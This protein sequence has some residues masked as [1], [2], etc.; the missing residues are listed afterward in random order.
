MS[1]KHKRF[2]IILAVM[3]AILLLTGCK[4][5]SSE[6]TGAEES[7]QDMFNRL[8]VYIRG[9]FEE[10]NVPGGS[11]A[12]ITNRILSY[13]SGIGVRRFDSSDQVDTET[14]FVTASAGKM[15]TAAAVMT[16]VDEGV[17]NLDAPVTTYVP[18]FNLNQPFDPANITVHQLLTHTSGLPG[19]VEIICNTD[20]NILS[21]WFR[22]HTNYP[23]WGP[24]GRLFNY[25]N[26]GYSL[27][28]L[29]IEEV[30]GIPFIDA[31]KQGIYDPLGMTTASYL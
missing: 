26:L 18:Y 5:R 24:P 11:I 10:K 23:L 14:L 22:E 31:M 3:F 4:S 15:L 29:I 7:G 2:L 27:V 20:E 28:G 9:E 12:V 25:S 30:S 1:K 16:L 19:Y 21:G 17:V 8:L 13:S 6:T